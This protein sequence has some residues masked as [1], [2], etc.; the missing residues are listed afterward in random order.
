MA[1]SDGHQR[2]RRRRPTASPGSCSRQCEWRAEK[3]V[4][5]STLV[6]LFASFVGSLLG[7]FSVA[8]TARSQSRS[9]L[10]Q[11]PASD[12]IPCDVCR[13]HAP[14]AHQVQ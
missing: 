11:S 12:T 13:I 10:R 8:R 7:C 4:C 3:P 6:G 2:R 5:I 9:H 1:G 14:N